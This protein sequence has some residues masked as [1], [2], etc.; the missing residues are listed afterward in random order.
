MPLETLLFFLPIYKNKV[1][2]RCNITAISVG[3]GLFTATVIFIIK[4]KILS[5]RTGDFRAPADTENVFSARGTHIFTV[6]SCIRKVLNAS[7]VGFAVL[8]IHDLSQLRW[9]N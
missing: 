9:K 2:V 1:P 6:N 4:Y 5:A 7:N 8:P 3:T